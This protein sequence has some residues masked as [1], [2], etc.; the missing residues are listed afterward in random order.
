[1]IDLQVQL[2]GPVSGA[3]R[4]GTEGH[5]GED[6]QLIGVDYCHPFVRIILVCST[7]ISDTILSDDDMMIFDNV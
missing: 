7:R 4:V 3:D 2:A 5:A 6:H 1:M